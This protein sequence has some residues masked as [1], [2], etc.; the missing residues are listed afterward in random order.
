MRASNPAVIPRNHK[1]Q[2]ALNFASENNDLTK[3]HDLLKVLKNPYV[4]NSKLANYQSV[5]KLGSEK[6]ETFCGT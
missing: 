6:Y 2:D 4:D 3:I 1:V 5:P